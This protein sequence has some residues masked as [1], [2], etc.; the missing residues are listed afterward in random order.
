MIVC[1]EGCIGVGKTS[2]VKKL[3]SE[4]DGHSIFEEF[5]N[6]PFL[7]EFYHDPDQFAFHVQATFLFLQSKQFLKA[8]AFEDGKNVFADFHPV[9]SKIFSDIVIKNIAD[10]GIIRQIYDRL[11]ADVEEKVL[12]VYL[13][14]NT[15]VI[16]NRIRQRKDPFAAAISAAY[17]EKIINTYN[18]YFE[19]YTFPFITIDTNEL[20]FEKNDADWRFVQQQVIDAMNAI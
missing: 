14:A 5:E 4:M 19:N 6:N 10:Y 2:L 3:A 13:K 18:S 7:K 17:I 8:L 11:F 15:E 16:L 9:K 20:D 1:I 12:I